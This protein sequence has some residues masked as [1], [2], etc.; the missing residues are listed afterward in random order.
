MVVQEVAPE[1]Q[2]VFAKIMGEGGNVVSE[3]QG[4]K[5]KIRKCFCFKLFSRLEPD[6]LKLEKLVPETSS[7]IEDD[8]LRYFLSL[9][10][11]GADELTKRPESMAKSLSGKKEKTIWKQTLVYIL[12]LF[13]KL[14]NKSLEKEI[15]EPLSQI[16]HFTKTRDYAQAD[17]SYLLLAIGKAA[18]PM[19]VTS[20]GIHERAAREKISTGETA[21]VLNDEVQRKYIQAVKRLIS[22]AQKHFPSEGGNMVS[23]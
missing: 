21:H 23:W 5:K 20:V 3:R 4:K 10:Q 13:R 22:F 15:L 17:N 14:A 7:G 11:M 16:M 6:L 9:I 19:G 8:L 12:P 18:W 2:N 1:A